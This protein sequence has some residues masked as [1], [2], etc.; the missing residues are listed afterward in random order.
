MET[1]GIE[2][3]N[4]YLRRAQR[5]QA[6]ANAGKLCETFQIGVAHYPDG[7]YAVHIY[8][9]ASSIGAFLNYYLYSFRS[10]AENEE[11][12][13]GAERA[14]KTIKRRK[15]NAQKR[16]DNAAGGKEEECQI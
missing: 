7:A 2:I 10:E 13:A 15:I 3:M 5:L 14:I 6:K 8:F 16:A 1:T 4:K 11:E 12:L 9:R